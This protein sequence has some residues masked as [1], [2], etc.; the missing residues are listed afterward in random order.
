MPRQSAQAL[1]VLIPE[2][3]PPGPHRPASLSA[4][5]RDVWRKTLEAVPR[6]YFT[7]Q[8][9]LL[10]QEYCRLAVHV[11][12][13]EAGRICAS[14]GGRSQPAADCEQPRAAGRSGAA[15]A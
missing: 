2:A 4:A 9:A 7:E 3:L 5:Q 1:S 6:G 12:E 8:D 11:D 13:L 15:C 14:G 10:L